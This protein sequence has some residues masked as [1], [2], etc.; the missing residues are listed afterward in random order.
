MFIGPS[1][2]ELSSHFQPGSLL[3][4]NGKVDGAV[5][6]V[7]NTSSR[8]VGRRLKSPILRPR[9]RV[10]L[11]ATEDQRR[12][13]RLSTALVVRSQVGRIANK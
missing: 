13:G 7:K 3:G 12:G 6:D 9:P 8:R 11:L 4:W 10:C 5:G 2:I 1:R